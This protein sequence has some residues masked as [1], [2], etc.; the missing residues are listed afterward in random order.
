M[1]EDCELSS[2][3]SFISQKNKQCILIYPHFQFEAQSDNVSDLTKFIQLM[4]LPQWLRYKESACK[5]GD[6]RDTGSI[7][8][9]ED[10]LKEEVATTPVLLPRKSDDQRSVV[11]YNPWNR[12]EWNMTERLSTH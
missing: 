9:W 2:V 1:L 7:L 8:G 11:G 5:A 4:G 12:K 3:V 10:P 6:V